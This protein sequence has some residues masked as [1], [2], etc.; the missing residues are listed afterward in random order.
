MNVSL[1]MQRT[2]EPPKYGRACHLIAPRQGNVLNHE[3]LE[4]E[5][6]KIEDLAVLYLFYAGT[7]LEA[8]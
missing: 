6:S 3:V 8:V 5:T 4:Q 2:H 7:R 1:V